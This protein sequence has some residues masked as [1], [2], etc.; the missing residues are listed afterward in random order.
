MTDASLTEVRVPADLGLA[1][2]TLELDSR[3][4]DVTRAV[5]ACMR[6]LETRGISA[7]A[8]GSFELVLAEALNNIVEHAYQEQPGGV[9]A[10]GVVEWADRIYCFVRDGGAPM[11]GLVLPEG[12]EQDLTLPLE[13]M[14]EGGF[15]WFLIHTLTT[16]LGYRRLG[17]ENRL[18][19][20]LVA[21]R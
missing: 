16:D 1:E 13:D 3:P 4:A 15:G 17:D 12:R 11:P 2:F 20:A 9:I 18:S 10:L 7:D 6:W 19:F 5:L 14:P 8:R 21:P